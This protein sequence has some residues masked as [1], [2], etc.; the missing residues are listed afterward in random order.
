MVNITDTNASQQ[1]LICP[2]LRAVMA[3]C[4]LSFKLL[5]LWNTKSKSWWFRCHKYWNTH[6]NTCGPLTVTAHKRCTVTKGSKFEICRVKKD[7][8]RKCPS[9]LGPLSVYVYLYYPCMCTSI[10]HSKAICV[11]MC[12]A[13][14]SIKHLC[15]FL[16][17]CF[18]PVFCNAVILVF[19]ELVL[20][21][22]LFSK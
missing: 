4:S 21:G 6:T 17:I 20:T 13:E 15:V 18:I 12:I 19:M 5:G 7:P 14:P 9:V 2:Y 3:Q 22:I 16:C 11:C 8:A 1:Q 10:Y